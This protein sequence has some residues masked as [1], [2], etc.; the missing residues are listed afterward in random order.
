MHPGRDCDVLQLLVGGAVVGAFAVSVAAGYDDSM[1]K[2][3]Q[4]GLS[5]IG[6]SA[7][8]LE[9]LLLVSADHHLGGV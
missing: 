5:A 6:P 7:N 8:W 2:P 1:M 3:K 9:A 4:N